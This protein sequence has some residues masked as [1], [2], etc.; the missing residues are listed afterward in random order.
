MNAFQKDEMIIFGQ[1]SIG[2]LQ[3]TENYRE[4]KL[5]NTIRPKPVLDLSG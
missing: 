3:F 1:K 4:L 5:S 2:E